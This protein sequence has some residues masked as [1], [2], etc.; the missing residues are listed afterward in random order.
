M[1]RCQS[2]YLLLVVCVVTC[3]ARLAIP[4]SLALLLS[5]SSY[6]RTGKQFHFQQGISNSRSRPLT[7]R[8][9]QRL[10]TG[11]RR[12]TGWQELDFDRSGLLRLGNRARLAGGSVTARAL[13]VAAIDGRHSFQLENHDFS[14]AI[15]FAQIRSAAIYLDAAGVRHEVFHLEFDFQDFAELR[16]SPE[17]VAA[18]DPAML[19]FH[20]LG[21]GVLQLGDTLGQGDALG[22]CERHMNRIRRELG[23]PERQHYQTR[24]TRAVLPGET[25]TQIKS[26]LHFVRAT[27]NRKRKDFYLFFNAETVALAAVLPTGQ[28]AAVRAA[29]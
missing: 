15:G 2:I 18:F 21:H 26:E 4:G 12:K 6:A 5:L 9:L 11:L 19:L 13:L 27:G 17:V 24:N 28:C 3:I 14:P 20:E 25:R 16:G 23:L 10:L 7:D 29:K 22:A 1:R 8:Q